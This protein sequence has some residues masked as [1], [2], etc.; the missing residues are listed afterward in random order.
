MPSTA[1]VIP[2]SNTHSEA[3][4]SLF[5]QHKL[6]GTKYDGS[7]QGMIG[8]MLDSEIL[9]DHRRTRERNLGKGFVKIKVDGGGT[10][11]LN[12]GGRI[13]YPDA[14]GNI[15]IVDGGFLNEMAKQEED[16]RAYLQEMIYKASLSDEI[17]AQMLGFDSVE[18]TDDTALKNLLGAG[19]SFKYDGVNPLDAELTAVNA[20]P[21]AIESYSDESVTYSNA[22]RKLKLLV[23]MRMPAVETYTTKKTLNEE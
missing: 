22:I 15:T 11:G 6:Q 17:C 7:R 3:Q 9:E 2:A 12:I 21:S 1:P 20:M 5:S 4:K 13:H 16:R 10:Q 18:G 23:Q 14:N 8:S 19:K